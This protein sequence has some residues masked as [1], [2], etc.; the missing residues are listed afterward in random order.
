MYRGFGREIASWPAIACP[1]GNFYEFHF[2][3]PYQ[4]GSKSRQ[5]LVGEV[6]GEE[7]GSFPLSCLAARE[8]DGDSCHLTLWTYSSLSGLLLLDKEGKVSQGENGRQDKKDTIYKVKEADPA[9][10]S[11][12]LGFSPSGLEGRRIEDVIPGFYEEFEV[13]FT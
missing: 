8:E 12:V 5:A 13:L 4:A 3:L 10:S 11:L 6:W 2:N 9:F 7:G 1:R